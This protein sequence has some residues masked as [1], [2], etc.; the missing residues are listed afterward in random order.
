MPTIGQIH[1]DQALT[2]LS[3][4]YRNEMY[5]AD[6]ALPI[7]PVSKRSDKYFVYKKEDFL[8]PSASGA[9]G[10]PSSVRRPGTEAAEIDYSLSTQSFYAEEYAY[11]G[12][13]ADAEVSIADNPLQPDIDQSLQLAERLMLDNETAVAKLVGTRAQYPGS[14]KAALTTGATGT[15]WASYA[16]P[17]SNPFSDIKNGKLAV[18][19]GIAREANAIL[20]SV[21]AARTL[22]DHPA[23]KDL[24]KYTNQDALTMSG[25]PKVIRG[26]EVIEGAAQK[27]VS[28]EG[29]SYAGGNVWAADDGSAMA[30]IFYRTTTPSLRGVSFGY[31]F[32]APDDTTGSRG[33]TVRR[34]R[35]EKRKGSLIEASFLRDWKLIA[36]DSAGLSLGG[37]LLSNVTA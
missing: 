32:E 5:V 15:S 3:L 25:L 8:S 18:V 2:N 7:L 19:K 30:L 6:M 12:F 22:A 27:N 24:I 31:T 4:M 36:Q 33:M 11:R 10:L 34:W 29:G 20:L 26:L 16:S 1:I 23:V 28:P 37:Y 17:N 21:D 14:N 35:E 13:V 9:S